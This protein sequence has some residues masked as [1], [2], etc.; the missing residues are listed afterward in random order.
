MQFMNSFDNSRMRQRGISLV[1]TL[2][3]LVAV[4]VLGLSAILISKGE[5]VLSGNLQFQSASLNEA[6]AAAIAA[7]QWLA[8]NGGATVPAGFT[9]Y[10]SGATGYQY[11]IGYLATNSVDPLTMTW[12]NSN[13]FAVPT[14]PPPTTTSPCTT[15]HYLIEF[16]AKDKALIP[17]SLNTGG[18]AATGCNKV[19]LFRIVASGTSGRGA[20]RFV[21]SVYSTLSC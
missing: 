9:T 17:V 20:T 18:R 2:V 13:S 8:T 16:L 21:Q 12:S 4:M 15:Q 14:C 19:N 7:E 6:E 5:F 3:M 11:P 10:S 1:T